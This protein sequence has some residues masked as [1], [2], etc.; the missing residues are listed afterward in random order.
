MGR[1]LW[2]QKLS[3]EMMEV[4]D[5]ILMLFSLET[6]PGTKSDFFFRLI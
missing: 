4:L 5:E 6:F 2:F 1:V 3:E